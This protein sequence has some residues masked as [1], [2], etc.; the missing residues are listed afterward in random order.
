MF[1]EIFGSF[2]A[3]LKLEIS[4]QIIIAVRIHKDQLSVYKLSHNY[5]GGLQDS[6]NHNIKLL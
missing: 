6:N 3:D 5:A 1:M 2:T 4:Q